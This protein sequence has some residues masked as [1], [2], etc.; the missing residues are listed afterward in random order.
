M[1]ESAIPIDKIIFNYAINLPVFPVDAK[2]A[3]KIHRW[4]LFFYLAFAAVVKTGKDQR[5]RV[6]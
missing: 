3:G 6:I 2:S 1:P 5:R 4:Y